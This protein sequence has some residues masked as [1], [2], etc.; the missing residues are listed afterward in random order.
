MAYKVM[1]Q[2]SLSEE[3]PGKKKVPV[4]SDNSSRGTKPFKQESQKVPDQTVFLETNVEYGK[5]A[6]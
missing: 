3:K 1:S 2:M 4:H 6:D 5:S